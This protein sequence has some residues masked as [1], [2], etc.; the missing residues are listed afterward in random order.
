MTSQRPGTSS[1]VGLV[2]LLGASG[3]LHLARPATFDGIV[4]KALPGEARTWT[5]ASGIAELGTALAL[6][7]PHTRRLAGALA[8]LL[9]VAVFP[10]NVTMTVDSFRSSRASRLK[11]VITAV[12]L[13]LQ[14]PLVL[15]A[16][17]VRHRARRP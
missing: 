11:K 9:F 16:L 14:V 13:P 12:R 2:A 3:A 17:G 10:A 8:A 1:L 5:Y 4:P 6:A 15:L 7:V